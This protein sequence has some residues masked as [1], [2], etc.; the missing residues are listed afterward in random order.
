MFNRYLVL[1]FLFFG[2]LWADEVPRE[3]QK[4]VDDFLKIKTFQAKIKQT[5]FVN[6]AKSSEVYTGEIYFDKSRLLIEYN[7]PDRQLIY[8]DTL[9]SIV[10]IE[11]SKQKIV[12]P[13]TLVFWPNVMVSKF[14]K[15]AKDFHRVDE[16][17]EVNFSFVPDISKN[18]NVAKVE[19]GSKNGVINK[20]K[21]YDFEE[22]F[23]LYEFSDLRFKEFL[24]NSIF[25][26]SFPE[27]VETIE[28]L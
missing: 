23:V 7:V 22:N 6:L 1:I 4:C 20:V 15:N 24:D 11:R 21:Y 8:A 12:S 19:I 18:E 3:L 16:N 2:F 17:G 13:P 28:N 9:Q 10:Y 14:V 5:N 25:M 27:D 26:L